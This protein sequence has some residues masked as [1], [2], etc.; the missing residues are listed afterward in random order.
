M[1]SKFLGFLKNNLITFVFLI[2][3]IAFECISIT[4]IGCSP[5][6]SKPLY[7]LVF[8][9][10]LGTL[11]MLFKSSRKKVVFGSIILFLQIVSNIG[12]LYLYD[13]NG[14]FFEWAMFNQR[15]DAYATIEEFALRWNLL[16][17]L[18]VL[19]ASYITICV[20]IHKFIYKAKYFVYRP[21]IFAKRAILA[22]L[23]IAFTLTA[24]IPITTAVS[25][26]DDNYVQKYLYGSAD[27][28]YQQYGMTSN[29]VYELFNGTI[30]DAL[31]DYDTE[32]VNDFIFKGQNPYLKTTEYN[33]ISKENNLVLV[34][35]ESFEWFAFFAPESNYLTEEQ[36]LALYPNLNKFLS[37]SVYANNFYAREKTDTSELLALVGNNPT[38]KFTNYDFPNNEFPW[39]LPNMF[40]E[41]A[42]SNGY[43]YSTD[44]SESQIS[45]RSFH[46]N[47]GEFYNRKVLH[48]SI[49]FDSFTA[50]EDMEEFGV[51]DMWSQ[52]DV[53]GER[54]PDSI[55]MDKM[56]YEMLPND[57]EQFMTFWITFAMHGYYKEKRPSFT[58]Y[59]NLMDEYNA[60]P[61]GISEKDDY[62]RTYAAAVMDFDK[63]LGIMMDT[64]EKQGQLEDTTIVLFSD[65]NCYY[66]NL[67]YYAKGINER[68][69][70]EVYRIPFM[71]YDQK[72]KDAYVAN[73][74]S[75]VITKF[76]TTSDIIPTIYDLF[77][78]KCY[79]NLFYGSSMF[80][81]KVESII[82]SRAYEIFITDKLI[83][84]SVEG[85]KY[86]SPD[87]T[88]ADLIDFEK[89]ATTHLE[90]QHIIDKIYYNNYFKNHPFGTKSSKK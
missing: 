16:I 90:K 12:F 49:G 41:N 52:D 15:N 76:T 71:I 17:I 80:D 78:I 28:K 38:G 13:S 75:N 68:H 20:L 57:K 60:F 79:K 47:D 3:S 81:K 69:N 86:K 18:L 9:C 77:G 89:R 62:I 39:S 64:L 5:F 33:G 65:H 55:T 84:Y 42:I 7:P 74:G 67:S 54:N 37:E 36:S 34:L 44:S 58:E 14:T 53:E 6:L 61:E 22:S 45:V 73:E 10:L 29:A 24:C 83:C 2:F 4:F 51:I 46:Q 11:I 43:T 63:A 85:L 21:T 59:Y 30:A 19:Y 82:F 88:E 56:R 66:S 48:E 50:I 40:R 1:L 25:S 32:G 35:V 70:S 26:V 72:L 31:V 27:N 87:F 8:F 23:I